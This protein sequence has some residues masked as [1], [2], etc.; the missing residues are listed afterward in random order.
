MKNRKMPAAALLVAIILACASSAGYSQSRS[1]RSALKFNVPRILNEE[2]WRENDAE[3]FIWDNHIVMSGPGELTTELARLRSSRVSFVTFSLQAGAHA[4]LKKSTI[5]QIGGARI[6]YRIYNNPNAPADAYEDGI[7]EV[8]IMAFDSLAPKGERWITS[9]ILIGIAEE[10]PNNMEVNP[11][12]T[13]RLDRESPVPVWD[14]YLGR[15]LLLA[16]IGLLE[17]SS[18]SGFRVTLGDCPDSVL[19]TFK[20]YRRNPLFEDRNVNGVY[21]PFEIDKLGRLTK[22]VGERSLPLEDGSSLLSD[23]LVYA[24]SREAKE[25]GLL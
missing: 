5:V 24:T 13:I 1:S 12:I 2:N 6:G 18:P 21:D 16:N 17:D 14:L 25:E 4:R 22:H 10:E 23:Y 8:E 7:R 19:S 11:A 20:I 15:R 3:V 9:N